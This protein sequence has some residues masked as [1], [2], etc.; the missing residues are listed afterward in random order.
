[1]SELFT[2]ASVHFVLRALGRLGVANRDVEDV[3]QEVFVTAHRL[4]ASYDASR[5]PEPWLYGLAKNAAR[6]HRKLVR[7]AR[8]VPHDDAV[9]DPSTDGR[10]AA[11]ASDQLRRALATLDDELVDAIILCDLSEL[12]VLETA[13]AL[14]VAEGTLKDRLRRGRAALRAELARQRQEIANG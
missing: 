12:T 4:V 14:G 11:V 3:A 2:E 13:A 9:G 8:E 7:H 5:R 6:N 10:T 1:M